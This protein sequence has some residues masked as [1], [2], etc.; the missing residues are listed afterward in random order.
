MLLLLM[1]RLMVLL[2][3]VPTLKRVRTGG[4]KL[5]VVVARHGR[6]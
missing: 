6:H 4:R 1:A 5:V 2:H 3:K